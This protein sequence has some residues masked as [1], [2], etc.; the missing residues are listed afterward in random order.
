LAW[1]GPYAPAGPH[2]Q[3]AVR[4]DLVLGLA[5]VRLRV[6]DPQAGAA[7]WARLMGVAV[8]CDKAGQ[9]RL[10]VDGGQLLWEPATDG[11]PEGLVGIDLQVPDVAAILARAGAMGL[12]VHAHRA[13]FELGGVRWTLVGPPA[14]PT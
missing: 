2:W 6:A 8:G 10:A 4:T 3:Q 9:P 13:C 14:L 12:P 11:Q 7:R 5:G 1:D